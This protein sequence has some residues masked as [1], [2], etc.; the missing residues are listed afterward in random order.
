MKYSYL[1]L[2]LCFNS[3]SAQEINLNVSLAEDFRE[4]ALNSLSLKKYSNNL[5]QKKD[6]EL[7]SIK[8]YDSSIEHYNKAVISDSLNCTWIYYRLGSLNEGF[9]SY[10]EAI[11]NYNKALNSNNCEIYFNDGVTAPISY[12]H[13]HSRIA[14]IKTI[15]KDTIGAIT[16]YTKAIEIY[17]ENNLDYFYSERAKLKIEMLD[18]R[19]AKLDIL[20]ALKINEY[21]NYYQLIGD[22]NFYNLEN[23]NDAIIYYKKSLKIDDKNDSVYNKIGLCY[24]SLNDKENACLNFSKG[25][26]LGNPLAYEN[27]KDFCQK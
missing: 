17:D 5:K 1:F 23:Y 27:I 22:I 21:S 8:M 6:E 11:E 16:N 15:L 4:K 10:N 24:I 9:E 13:I 14:K 7:L 19:G 12:S 3:I 26:E 2:I 18:F 20:E 25:G